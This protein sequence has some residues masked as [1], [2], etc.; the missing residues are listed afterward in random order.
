M[1]AL[2]KI[3]NVLPLNLNPVS[4]LI[5]AQKTEPL[6][7]G[8]AVS[9]VACRASEEPIQLTT[10]YNGRL[11][12]NTATKS[13]TAFIDWLSFTVKIPNIYQSIPNSDKSSIVEVVS[14]LL[15]EA[16]GFGVTSKRSNGYSSYTDSYVLGDDWGYLCIGGASQR[17][18]LLVTINGQGNMAATDGYTQRLYQLMSKLKAKITRVDLAADYFSGYSEGIGYSVDKAV[19]DY[20]AGRYTISN[21]DPKL[22]QHGNWIKPDGTGRTLEIGSSKTGKKLV[23]YEKGLH[24]GGKYAESYK[25][26]C[27]VEL[28]LY[29]KGRVIPLDV[30]TESGVYL[31]GAYPALEF[32]SSKQCRIKA[33]KAKQKIEYEKAIAVLK[34]QFGKYLYVIASTEGSIEKVITHAVPK[35]LIMP[36]AERV[37]PESP[38]MVFEDDDVDESPSSSII[39][40]CVSM[41]KSKAVELLGGTEGEYRIWDVCLE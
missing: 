5:Q 23:V 25:D 41:V 2:M 39:S 38:V 7:K 29:N 20:L 31:A 27:R 24:I 21:T 30:I 15:I 36:D 8:V 1:K 33:G 14:S 32:I 11:I 22:N 9:D 4:T 16:V 37:V 17:N 12:K 35:R 3:S 10:E 13:N 19:E 34:K 40:E 18:T 26:W 6:T 28:R